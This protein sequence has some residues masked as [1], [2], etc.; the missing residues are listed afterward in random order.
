MAPEGGCPDAAGL[1][2]HQNGGV[3]HAV[4]SAQGGINLGIVHGDLDVGPGAASVR[5]AAHAHVN[6]G[7]Q[8]VGTVIAD[9]IHSQKGTFF[10]PDQAGNAVEFGIEIPMLHYGN[11]DALRHQG[12]I[13]HL[14]QLVPRHNAGRAH[15]HPAVQGGAF[16]HRHAGP[17]VIVAGVQLQFPLHGNLGL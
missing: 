8:V 5:G 10:R 9:I 1:F 14:H 13:G 3:P 7:R 17:Q 11:A 2:I 16:L 4:G 6:I 15:H 12:G